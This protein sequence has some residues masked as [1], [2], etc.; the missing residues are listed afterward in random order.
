MV[1]LKSLIDFAEQAIGWTVVG[2]EFGGAFGLANGSAE[3][4]IRLHSSRGCFGICKAKPD[5][6]FDEA[7][8]EFFGCFEGAFGFFVFFPFEIDIT[9]LRI[10]MGVFGEKF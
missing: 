6:G 8:V 5:I 3:I 2:I 10:H 1:F 4:P 7:F 9:Q